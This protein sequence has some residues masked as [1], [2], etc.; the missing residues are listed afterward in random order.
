[1]TAFLPNVAVRI[2]GLPGQLGCT[3]PGA[4]SGHP[5]DT[6]KAEPAFHSNVD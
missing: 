3:L 2:Q 5:G 1:M 4:A 6:I